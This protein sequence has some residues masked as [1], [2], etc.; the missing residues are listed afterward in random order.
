MNTSSKEIFIQSSKF[1]GLFGLAYLAGMPQVP[2][3]MAGTLG[4]GQESLKNFFA[5]VG[6]MVSG[7]SANAFTNI[8]KE[9]KF[10]VSKDLQKE[11]EAAYENTFSQ[12]ENIILETDETDIGNIFNIVIAPVYYRK[13]RK[14]KKLLR[15]TLINP[16][17]ADLKNEIEIAS[18]LTAN[19]QLQPDKYL[20]G[21]IKENISRI[22]F[23]NKDENAEIF[24]EE[25]CLHF[26]NIFPTHFLTSLKKNENAR[27]TY[28]KHLLEG[29]SLQTQLT[30]EQLVIINQL[31]IQTKNDIAALNDNILGLNPSVSGL[32]GQL[33]DFKQALEKYHSHNISCMEE[34]KALLL[35]NH[36]PVLK[37]DIR[38]YENAENPNLY[39]FR[40]QFTQLRGRDI[41]KSRLRDFIYLPEINS[42]RFAWCLLTG[43]GGSGKSRIAQ[44]LALE[45]ARAG[46][47][48]GF[49]NAS[50]YD[51]DAPAGWSRWE[52]RVP[53]FIII[54]YAFANSLKAIE[55][56]R[57]LDQ[58]NSR[59]N[60]GLPAI[61]LL[62]LE[63]SSN[64]NWEDKVRG[65]PAVNSTQHP[66]IA[67]GALN[68]E[69]QW[70]I[71]SDVISKLNP[72][73]I[74]EVEKSKAD[75]LSTLDE[76][77]QKRRPL[78][79]FLAA[80]AL[81]ESNHIRYWN[82]HQLLTHVNS[83]MIEL[84]NRY[85]VYQENAVLINHLLVVNTLSRYLQLSEIED[86]CY[87]WNPN[88]YFAEIEPIYTAFTDKHTGQKS[89]KPFQQGIQPD[90]LGEYYLL[91]QLGTLLQGGRRRKEIA[92]MLVLTAWRLFP[93]QTKWSIWLTFSDYIKLQKND[94]DGINYDKFIDTRDFLISGIWIEKADDAVAAELASLY[95]YI[96]DHYSNE[97]NT[98]QAATYIGF[99]IRMMEHRPEN[100]N[101]TESCLSAIYAYIW[102]NAAQIAQV[103]SYLLF[104]EQLLEKDFYRDNVTVLSWLAK[105]VGVYFGK[106][107]SVDSTEWGKRLA[108]VAAITLTNDRIPQNHLANEFSF[109]VG[110]YISREGIPAAACKSC[111]SE[112]IA[113]IHTLT[114]DKENQLVA[115]Y[116]KCIHQF[117]IRFHAEEKN[118][119]QLYLGG[120]Q[121]LNEKFDLKSNIS[122]IENFTKAMNAAVENWCID[123]PGT[124]K[125]YLNVAS[126]IVNDPQ[127]R[128]QSAEVAFYFS[129]MA[130]KYIESNINTDLAACFQY[131]QILH[132]LINDQSVKD[133]MIA[134]MWIFTISIF[135]GNVSEENE[136]WPQLNSM[137]TSGLQ[138]ELHFATETSANVFASF[139]KFS[140]RHEEFFMAEDIPDYKRLVIKLFGTYKTKR[141]LAAMVSL[142]RLQAYLSPDEAE[143][144]GRESQSTI[145]N[146]NQKFGTAYTMEDL[147]QI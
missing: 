86:L 91:D 29:V 18:M 126:D 145:D 31:A 2:A 104:C 50:Q 112:L 90:I 55:I 137:F 77:D 99:I 13:I 60:K 69:S 143:T 74:P 9:I 79:T 52:P 80:V 40:Y 3:I 141:T 119:C 103:N 117:I 23:I 107:P 41:E 5:L 76:I 87:T 27:I 111:I 78:F 130:W 135:S 65:N 73:R 22:E 6:N 139:L 108:W 131:F 37:I 17:L 15:D 8:G 51:I 85:P 123:D 61:R 94:L 53:V 11:L 30:N 89:G 54:D 113:L 92:E 144:Y 101:I 70:H 147:L 16:I 93:E 64:Q 32:N 122:F 21:L 36:A 82:K 4:L 45:A 114:P 72:A 136:L 34:I 95:E 102:Y 128:S 10:L 33:A 118:Q 100:S 98:D 124:S 83:R 71:M 49:Y 125:Y 140:M 26:K 24:I 106:F 38:D 25:L 133:D 20:A 14:D 47:Y 67:L 1:L 121:E 68:S 28:F 48:A 59:E 46:Y 44:E 109:C 129:F 39:H 58:F 42:K 88:V 138:S 132:S 35:S 12:I 56:I 120:L 146:F 81:S 63:R 115:N 66:T 105:I 127:I 7:F 97:T 84:W 96:A 110:A 19:G 62:L 116:A 134:S 57:M 142:Y 75:W 43:E